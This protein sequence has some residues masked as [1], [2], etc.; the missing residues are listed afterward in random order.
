MKGLIHLEGHPSF[1]WSAL[2]SHFCSLFETMAQ[3]SDVRAA[4]ALPTLIGETTYI[5]E[6]LS[7]KASVAVKRII[8]KY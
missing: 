1:K 2:K 6:K 4:A 8:T 3:A 5:I 7:I